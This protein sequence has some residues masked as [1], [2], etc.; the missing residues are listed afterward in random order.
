M[1]TRREW[2]LLTGGVVLGAGG[3]RLLRAAPRLAVDDNAIEIWKSATCGCCKQWVEH[4][5]ANGF[6]PTTHDVLDVAPFKQKY[7]VPAALAS[8]HTAVVSGY[9]IEGHV[10]ADVVRQLL[11]ERPKVLGLAVP[12]MP[13]GSPG[14]EGPR[15]D[16]YDVIAFAD[17]G[18][19]RVFARR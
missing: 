3:G 6:R 16:R 14:M 18:Q 12:G 5:R 7:R 10:P 1:T 11:K 4:M 8:C 19:T 9:A 13:M 15:K 17:N 2:L